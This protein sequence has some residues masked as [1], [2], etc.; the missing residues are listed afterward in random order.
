MPPLTE[1]TEPLDRNSHILLVL[2]DAWDEIRKHHPELPK[3]RMVLASGNKGGRYKYH[4]YWHPGQWA[5]ADDRLPEVLISGE[6]LADGARLTFETLLH[7][8][9]HGVA[10][11]R[12]IQDT[13]RQGRWHNGRFKALAEELGLVVEK[14]SRIGH[15]TKDITEETADRYQSE[16]RR[17]H[18]AVDGVFRVK[19]EGSQAAAEA[20]PKYKT[21]TCSCER[22]LRVREDDHG[23]MA[24][25]YCHLCASPFML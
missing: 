1:P 16:I 23:E 10:H 25:I 6:R 4:G 17:I 11:S 3:V 9:V 21:L 15:R 18:C 20:R 13:S 5:A 7:E 14:C 22:E 12:G 19:K 24:E 8:A 2:E